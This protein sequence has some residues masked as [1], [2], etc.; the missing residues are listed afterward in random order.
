M[1]K[2]VRWGILGCGNIA[3]KFALGLTTAKDSVLAATGSRSREKAEALADEYEA[4]RRHDSY[5]ALAADPDVDAIYVA[6]PHPMH[7]AHS[8]LCLEHGKPVLCEKPFTVNATEAREVIQTAGRRGVFLMEAQWT[9]FLPTIVLL[10]KLIAD[11]V[12]GEIRMV[13]ADFGFRSAWNPERRLLNPELAGGGLLDVGTYPISLANMVFGGP[14]AEITAQAHIGETGVDEQLVAT[15]SWEGGGLAALS[16]GVRTRT[17]QEAT[18]MGTEGFVRL[19]SPWWRNA[20]I[21]LHRSGQDPEE[22]NAPLQGNGY[23]YEAEE[24]ARCLASGLLES[25]G[26]SHT[27]TVGI[28]ETMDRIRSAIGLSYPMERSGE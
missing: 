26:M 6:T 19:A 1:S 15:G 13:L 14:P 8:L 18:I 28:M 22:L 11:G 24:V 4:P 17:P 16:C 21:F 25:E 5:E 10:R 20:G 23:N 2:P 12:L 3:R 27:D 7:R 9:R